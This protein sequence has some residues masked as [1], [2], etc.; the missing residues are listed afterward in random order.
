MVSRYFCMYEGR[1]CFFLI[2]FNEALNTFYLRLYGVGHMA[3]DNSDSES[4]NSLP[5]LHGYWFR[6][7]ARYFL[8]APTDRIADTTAFVTPVVEHWMEREIGQ[9]LHHEGSIRQPIAPR[10][11]AL[12]ME[13][14]FALSTSGFRRRKNRE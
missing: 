14:H 8:Y 6:L 9:W 4:G 2:I 12:T 5:P 13:L 1:K 10:T 11:I 3:K 7:A